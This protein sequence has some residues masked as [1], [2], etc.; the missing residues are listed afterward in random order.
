THSQR[1]CCWCSR[2]A[3]GVPLTSKPPM[4]RAPSFPPAPTSPFNLNSN[5]ESTHPR[6][7][8]ILYQVPHLRTAPS[9]NVVPAGA[10]III[11]VHPDQNVIEGRI[12][13]GE[14]AVGESVEIW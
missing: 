14:R 4:E 5:D 11:A 3:D 9:G 1:Y 2:P 12:R 10:R 13:L 7:H 6:L 8:E